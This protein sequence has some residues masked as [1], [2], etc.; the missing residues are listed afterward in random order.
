MGIHSRH[1]EPTGMPTRHNMNA[2]TNEAFRRTEMPGADRKHVIAVE[3]RPDDRK[4][5][6]EAASA[7]YARF[8]VI[9]C[10]AG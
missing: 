4:W 9:N 6:A 10:R 1:P 5:T 2:K 3:D 7:W 8:A